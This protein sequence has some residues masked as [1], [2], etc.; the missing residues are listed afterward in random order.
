MTRSV[1]HPQV[2]YCYLGRSDDIA[3]TDTARKP[4]KFCHTWPARESMFSHARC[5]QNELAVFQEQT[6][7]IVYKLIPFIEVA[8]QVLDPGK[9]G[10]LTALLQFGDDRVFRRSCPTETKLLFL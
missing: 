4:L 6:G 10:A 7:F 2:A 1:Y 9:S 8:R 5:D 3:R